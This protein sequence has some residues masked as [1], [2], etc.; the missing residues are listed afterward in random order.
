[1]RLDKVL[2]ICGIIKKRVL[3]NEV[4][5]LGYVK[6]NG[7]V[8]KPTKHIKVNDII[9]LNLPHKHYIIKILQELPVNRSIS[10][11]E[12]N[13]FFAIKEDPVRS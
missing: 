10:K 13:N 3:A 8:A 1:M 6:V 7:L 12:R 2:Q 5:K 11:Q 9:E 4:C